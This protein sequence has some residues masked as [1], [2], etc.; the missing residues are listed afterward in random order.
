MNRWWLLGIVSIL[1]LAGAV[2]LVVVPVP[3]KTPVVTA[4]ASLDDLITI[5]SPLPHSSVTSPLTITGRARGTWYFEA[6]FPIDIKDASGKVIAQGHAE[7]ESDW[8][9]ENYVPF[10]ATLSYPPQ[11]SGS[12]GVLVI[13]NDNPSGDPA[14]DK[15]VEIPV[16]F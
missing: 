5:D 13:K 16:V 14:R 9:T 15:K 4:P 6:S 2:A 11:Q 12:R 8:M 3:Q 10:K 1:I 7:A